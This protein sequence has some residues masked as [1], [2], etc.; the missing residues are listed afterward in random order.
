MLTPGFCHNKPFPRSPR[1]SA[2][3]RP[4]ETTTV[5]RQKGAIT[6]KG[7]GEW[8]DFSLRKTPMVCWFLTVYVWLLWLIHKWQIWG[9]ARNAGHLR[10]LEQH[11]EFHNPAENLSRLCRLTIRLTKV[12]A[13]ATKK[14]YF[15]YFYV[16]CSWIFIPPF[17]LSWKND[18]PEM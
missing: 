4:S 13:L 3:S 11:F 1:N 17:S 15:M 7:L 18:I 9:V 8:S 14:C 5:K 12:T 10:L 6:W 16:T 2:E